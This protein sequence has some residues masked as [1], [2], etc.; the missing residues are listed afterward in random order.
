MPLT[1]DTLPLQ[2]Y[3]RQNAGAIAAK[4]T[5]LSQRE[6]RVVRDYEIERENRREVLD[7]IAELSMAEPWAGYDEQDGA[8]IALA[9]AASDASTVRRVLAYERA[10]RSRAQ[11]IRAANAVRG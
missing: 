6:L 5:A 3:D 4:L 2:N 9:V 10:H 1:E 8:T 11:V 7:R